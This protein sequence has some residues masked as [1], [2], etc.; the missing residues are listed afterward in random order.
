MANPKAMSEQ[1][2]KNDAGEAKLPKDQGEYKV[3]NC[4][5]PLETRFQ[6]G[7]SGNPE[8]RKTAGATI[9]EHINSLSN[10]DLSE[11]ELRKIARDKE[12]PWTRRAAA[13]RILRTLEA[14]D[15]SDF[16]GL[17]RGEDALE[18]LRAMGVNTEPIKRFK[19]K[20]R[21]V[22]VP[23][24]PGE[25]EEVIDREIEL[26]DRAGDEFDRVCD[27]TSGRPQQDVKVTAEVTHEVRPHPD[28]SRLSIAER[29]K[30]AELLEKAC[31]DSQSSTVAHLL[32]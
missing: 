20:T 7:Q 21:K 12:Q 32:S 2:G 6:P 23:G 5:P 16:A 1:Q 11:A 4:K 8:G 14:P 17:L 9:K 18:D 15:I 24:Q 29:R 31:G 26:F 25:V 3:G 19:Q 22:A 27:R 13:E 30:M 10:A 28:M